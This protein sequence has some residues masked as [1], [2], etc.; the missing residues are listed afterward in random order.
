MSSEKPSEKSSEKSAESSKPW[1]ARLREAANHLSSQV[2]DDLR[3]LVTYVN[4]QVVPDVRRNGSVAL[5]AAA[6]EFS[7]L[8]QRVEDAN[9]K[10]QP[11]ASKPKP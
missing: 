8:A 5:R 3:T 10:S 1:D 11:P 9:R 6:A 2:E 4:D 7:R